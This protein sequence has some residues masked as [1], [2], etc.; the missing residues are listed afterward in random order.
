MSFLCRQHNKA[1]AGTQSRN[2]RIL[3]SGLL[4]T[5]YKAG[6]ATHQAAD[7]GLIYKGLTSRPIS[8]EAGK[9]KPGLPCKSV[10]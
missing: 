1:V 8:A 10:V 7:K 2:S 6:S 4:N 9:K 5:E 3:G